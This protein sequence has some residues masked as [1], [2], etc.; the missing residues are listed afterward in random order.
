[1]AFSS[2]DMLTGGGK[3]GEKGQDG[4]SLIWKGSS[5]TAPDSPGTNWAYL[6]T[7]DGNSYIWDGDSWEILVAAAIPGAPGV[8]V[9]WKGS[10]TAAPENPELNWAYYNT[11]DGSCYIWNGD[12]WDLMV[13]GTMPSPE[14]YNTIL[15]VDNAAAMPSGFA[16]LAAAYK[17][18]DIVNVTVTL[19]AGF[20]FSNLAA[21]IAATVNAADVTGLDPLNGLFTAIG[22]ENIYVHY[23]F[24]RTSWTGL[25]GEDPAPFFLETTGS[26][27]AY[28]PAN[29][30]V[31][32]PY[33]NQILSITMPSTLKGVGD[34]LFYDLQGLQK[35]S[36]AGCGNLTTINSYAFAAASADNTA[37]TDIEFTG[38][39]KLEYIGDYAFLYSANLRG[40]KGTDTL[41]LSDIDVPLL[42]IRDYAFFRAGVNGAMKSIKLP[43]GGWFGN[44]AFVR[45]LGVESVWITDGR[46]KELTWNNFLYLDKPAGHDPYGYS[47]LPPLWV[48]ETADGGRGLGTGFVLN[49]FVP[50]DITLQRMATGSD[51]LTNSEDD[52]NYFAGQ[53]IPT[54]NGGDVYR[55]QSSMTLSGEISDTITKGK[56]KFLTNGSVPNTWTVYS[57]PEA[58]S[59][60]AVGTMANGV[61]ILNAPPVAGLERLTPETGMAITGDPREYYLSA[62]DAVSKPE[63]GNKGQADLA[64]DMWMVGAGQYA[65]RTGYFWQPAIASN[66]GAPVTGARALTVKDF[67]YPAT[68]EQHERYTYRVYKIG[69]GQSKEFDTDG[70]GKADA[71]KDDI[72]WSEWLTK[73]YGGDD[74]L[75]TRTFVVD[76]GDIDAKDPL[77][78]YTLEDIKNLPKT[79]DPKIQWYSA[80]VAEWEPKKGDDWS[81]GYVKTKKGSEYSFLTDGGEN[82]KTFTKATLVEGDTTIAA[83]AA[84]VAAEKSDNP[85]IYMT[86]EYYYFELVKTEVIVDGTSDWKKASRV[87]VDTYCIVNHVTDNNYYTDRRK[88][89]YVYVSQDVNLLR[90]A[91]SGNEN[92]LDHDA[93]L[94][95][96]QTYYEEIPDPVKTRYSLGTGPAAWL[97]N[98]HSVHLALKAGWNQVEEK[99][100]YPGEI[101]DP[102]Q[103]RGI[104][105]YRISAGIQGP[106]STFDSGNNSNFSATA[107]KA[108]MLVDADGESGTMDDIVKQYYSDAGHEIP[109]PWVSVSLPVEPPAE[110]D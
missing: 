57:R 62:D 36:F 61:I 51:L 30:D 77:L 81:F 8:G 22:S 9:V 63:N 88:V 27:N 66:S 34:Y 12:A 5:P 47:S 44:N 45:N 18:H 103:Y 96:L 35:V 87:G 37:L 11:F 6:N 101:S 92:I 107:G 65:S 17:P 32:R 10:H 97:V 60:Y 70:D 89:Y 84:A 74:T 54:N 33:R 90:T 100:T 94:G 46:W 104:K 80:D 86:G 69:P 16:A 106:F 55:G 110:V 24:S 82:S 102:G 83:N 52:G 13:M 20:D 109:V 21:E 43:G 29:L 48:R 73:K 7:T 39:T 28:L 99:T 3:D 98:H 15:E 42:T 108:Y 38:C 19:A 26:G 68:I 71:F 1:M 64:G 59:R 75:M 40:S 93:E 50:D 56:D 91:K 67:Y 78:G 14:T 31:V 23:D 72:L 53:L 58:D 49:F 85:Q 4:L 25:D 2:C 76:E 105:T 95:V 41:D 79:G